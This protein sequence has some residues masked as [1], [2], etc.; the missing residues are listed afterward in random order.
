MIGK[1]RRRIAELL[2]VVATTTSLSGCGT[3]LSLGM[4]HDPDASQVYGG[5]RTDV[6]IPMVALRVIPTEEKLPAWTV[7]WSLL[8]LDLPFSFIADTVL[9]PVTL[10]HH[11][12]VRGKRGNEGTQKEHS[13]AGAPSP[14]KGDVSE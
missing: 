14:T 1:C 8:L 11:F 13:D 3:L 10:Y 4:N 6:F 7:A 5:T 12:A 2:V 9:L